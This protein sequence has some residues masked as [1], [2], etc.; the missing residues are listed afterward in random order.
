MKLEPL[1][2]VAS[3]KFE[4]GLDLAVIFIVVLVVGNDGDGLVQVGVLKTIDDFRH[5]ATTGLDEDGGGY[6]GSDGVG[7]GK[8]NLR[9]VDATWYQ[10]GHLQEFDVLTRSM[11]ETVGQR[12]EQPSSSPTSSC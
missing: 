12:K 9:V 4:S 5:D 7:V 6:D 11:E 10:H 2:I 8:V 3:L 1:V